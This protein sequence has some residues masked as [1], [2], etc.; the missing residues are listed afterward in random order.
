MTEK[1]PKIRYRQLLLIYSLA[2]II[3]GS[4]LGFLAYRGIQGNIAGAEK[5]RDER[6][7]RKSQHFFATIEDSIDYYLSAFSR[8]DIQ[9]NNNFLG[10]KENSP[11]D[12]LIREDI[13]LAVAGLKANSVVKLL[14][15]TALFVPDDNWDD[16]VFNNSQVMDLTM[17][18]NLEFDDLNLN[19][20]LLKYQSLDLSAT[21]LFIKME[22]LM[23]QA[24][25]HRK[26]HE[27]RE[28]R[29]LYRRIY[30]CAKYPILGNQIIPEV[31]ETMGS[32]IQYWFQ[33]LL[34]NT[35]SSSP[36]L[37]SLEVLSFLGIPK[38]YLIESYYED[39]F[40]N[41]RDLFD[42]EIKSTFNN[43]DYVSII[44]SL[45]EV[46]EAEMNLSRMVSK[47]MDQI[48]KQLT[49]AKDQRSRRGVSHIHYSEDSLSVL[50]VFRHFS[51]HSIALALNTK[52]LIR[53]NIPTLEQG[54]AYSNR[55]HWRI[56]DELNKP[57]HTDPEFDERKYVY[58]ITPVKLGIWTL[59]LQEQK[60][61][62]WG[63]IW[64]ADQEVYLIGFFFVIFVMLL[65]LGLS[66][67]GL[68]TDYRLTRLKSDFVSTISHEFKSPLTS[69][70][71]MSEML[72]K[73]RVS[74]EKRKKD[75][76]SSMMV[77][78]ERLSHLVDNI[79]D[80]S[81]MEDGRKR[82]HF[83]SCDLTSLVTDVVEIM[84]LRYRDI[85]FEVNLESGIELPDI[86]V[87]CDGIQQ[88]F[89][90]LID[91]AFKY[92]GDNKRIDIKIWHEQNEIRASVRDYGL[93]I[94]KKDQRRI[95][96]RFYRSEM[97]SI[98]GIK[99]SGIGLSIV[100]QIIKAHNGRIGLESEPGKGS[101]FSIYLPI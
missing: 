15:K 59:Q 88:V 95:Y 80:F 77:Q 92:S 34:Q 47:H 49:S 19:R 101:T 25:I 13:V 91:N 52:E 84:K 4:L 8:N 35:D 74:S 83:N 1:N 7:A 2:I 22:A 99:G 56:L 61:G 39:I 97:A 81:R 45:F 44:D 26:L 10:L 72:S 66:I 96:T 33:N 87:D 50:V 71:Q 93:G 82:Y 67:H 30:E 29:V 42:S 57:I 73:D 28:C 68:T 41:T 9:W 11:A 18:Y 48:R 55:I 36:D 40:K 89:Y 60:Q 23:G 64:E 86:A 5:I 37:L 53:R 79:L 90:N 3:P 51:Q 43:L 6:L 38:S 17:C 32:V 70:R 27:Y 69:I 58:S 12:Y 31:R 54:R 46:K 76:Y 62:W 94:S 75:Y 21:D 78:S 20:A 24:R 65:G 98:R 16:P 100:T 14:D 63:I 85:E